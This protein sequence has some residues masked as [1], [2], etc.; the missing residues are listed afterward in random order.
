[1]KVYVK[2]VG[3]IGTNCYIVAG[4]NQEAVIIDPGARADK[5]ADFIGKQDLKP[6]Y[7]LLTHG[8]FDHIGAVNALAAK[9]SCKIAIG[10][11]DA[12]LL[13]DPSKSLGYEG[14]LT[15]EEC[16]I[17]PDLLLHDGDVIEAGGMSFTVIETPGH[18]KGGVSYSCADA[19]FTG[20]TL[21]AGGMGRTDFYGGDYRT[22]LV[23]LQK[24]ARL[25]GDYHVFPGHGPD[26]TLSYERGTN[27]YLAMAG[28]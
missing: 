11:D 9:Y 15:K 24:L 4:D 17:Q 20:D 10:A 5:L 25:D 22:M 14:G 6:K 26:S 12:E 13:L 16:I 18:T 19:L 23:S 7:I 28:V 3:S 21:F 2:P 27:P 1:M 8:H